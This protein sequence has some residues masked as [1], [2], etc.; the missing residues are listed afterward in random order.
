SA[1]YERVLKERNEALI[2]AD[3]L[4]DTFVQNVSYELRSP[5][6]NIIGFADLLASEQVGP[7]SD[8]QRA[9]TDYIRASSAN[10][11]LLIDNILDLATVDAGIAQL[12]PEV[13]DIPALIDKARAGLAATFTGGEKPVDIE[14][15][16]EDGLPRFVADGTRIV[17]VL[18][19]L[20][21][22]AARFSD[23]GSLVRVKVSAR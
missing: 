20:L 21:S 1:N 13:L 8:K 10:L 17:Q 11:G 2:A 4:K 19:N 12:N 9:Y 16:I 5:L 15:T 14:V 7:L 3:R 6:T 23:P 18:Y 22:N